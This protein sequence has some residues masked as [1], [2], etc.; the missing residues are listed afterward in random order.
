[1]AE[2]H[3]RLLGQDKVRIGSLQL[4]K[5]TMPGYQ[6]TYVYVK[7]PSISLSDAICGLRVKMK[8]NTVFL[9]HVVRSFL[10]LHLYMVCCHT[11]I[12]LESVR[13]QPTHWTPIYRLSKCNSNCS[14]QRSTNSLAFCKQPPF[15]LLV[16]KRKYGES[17]NH[18]WMVIQVFHLLAPSVG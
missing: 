18:S 4:C 7:S 17:P 10:S 13:C 1:M 11:L 12:L 9:Y 2:S 14:V 3:L 6:W 16:S 8:T 5:F 15:R